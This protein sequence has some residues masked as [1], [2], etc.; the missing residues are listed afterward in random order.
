MQV[1]LNVA[2]KGIVVIAHAVGVKAIRCVEEIFCPTS[3]FYRRLPMASFTVDPDTVDQCSLGRWQDICGLR[4][5]PLFGCVKGVPFDK[6]MYRRG[7]ENGIANDH[8]VLVRRSKGRC[9]SIIGQHSAHGL[10]AD[11]NGSG[12]AQEIVQLGMQ[13]GQSCI[14]LVDFGNRKCSSNGENRSVLWS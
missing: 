7:C 8:S 12:V 9:G 1:K 3:K 14:R 11:R 6:N 4:H 10:M 5:P 2:A 13:S